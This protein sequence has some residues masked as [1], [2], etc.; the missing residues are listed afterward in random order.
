VHSFSG[1]SP[2]GLAT[3]FY[4]LRFETSLF[5]ASYDSQGYGGGIRPRFQPYNIESDSESYVTTD[6]QSTRLAWNKAS[7]LGLRPDFYYCQTLSGLLVWGALSEERTGLSFTIVPGPRQRSQSRV[8]DI[9]LSQIRDFPFRRLLRLAGLRW[10]YSTP[11]PHG[12]HECTAFYKMTENVIDITASKGSC[13]RCAGYAC[14]TVLSFESC[15]QIKYHCKDPISTSP[16]LVCRYVP[17][18]VKLR[19][20]V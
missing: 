20:V 5:V 8:R 1:L 6:G 15:G 7:I 10:R 14:S 9:L 19:A 3:I 18:Y 12:I 11:P 2:A 17:E 4:S 16:L 13:L